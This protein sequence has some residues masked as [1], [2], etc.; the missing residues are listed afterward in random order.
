MPQD[1]NPKNRHVPIPENV[2]F[3]VREDELDALERGETSSTLLNL[4]LVFLPS[5]ISM[6]ATLAF[7]EVKSDRTFNVF[8][9]MTVGSILAGGILLVLWWRASKS[10]KTVIKTIRARDPQPTGT[11]IGTGE[12]PA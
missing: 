12:P 11:A 3:H 7:S 4:A 2:I 10:R 5:G 1:L 6:W 8:T 9:A